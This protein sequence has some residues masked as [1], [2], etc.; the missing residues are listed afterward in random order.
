LYFTKGGFKN[1]KINKHFRKRDAL[2][3]AQQPVRLRAVIEQNASKE[4]AEKGQGK[5]EET[6]STRCT[7]SR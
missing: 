5:G 7:D 2:F 4:G 6:A 3:S 1:A